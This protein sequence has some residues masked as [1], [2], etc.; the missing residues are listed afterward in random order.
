MKENQIIPTK[1]GQ[2]VKSLIKLEGIEE[3]EYFI[4][5]EVPSLFKDEELVEVV[6]VT[7]F[8]RCQA[9]G[10]RPFGNLIKIN[11]LSVISE[12]IVEWVESWNKM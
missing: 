4:L 12:N 10:K 7:E 5:T 3:N 11:H 1:Q 8:L 9:I 6:A 2:I